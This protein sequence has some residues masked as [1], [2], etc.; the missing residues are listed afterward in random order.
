MSTNVTRGNS[1]SMLH[2][3]P[4]HMQKIAILYDASQAVLATFDLDEVLKQI[5]AIVRD[6]F[7]IQHGAILLLDEAKQELYFRSYFGYEGSDTSLRLPLGQGITGSAAKLKRPLYVLDVTQDPR[8]VETLPGTRSE[9][10]IPLMVRDQVVG[11][12]DCQSHREDVFDNE[13]VDLLT[14]FSTQAS[15][16]LQ[17]AHLH[18]LERRRTAQLEAINAI[19]R[20]TTALLQEDELLTKFST[21]I[22]ESFDV[23]EVCILLL[24]NDRL[25][26]RAQHGRLT[27][28]L[29]EGS[30]LPAISGLSGRALRLGHTVLENNVAAAAD[31]VPGF[32][33]SVSE[34][35]LPLISLGET[36]GVLALESAEQD[37]F[38]HADVPIL[39]SVADICATAIQNARNFA[40]VHQMAYIDGL[41]GA[42]NRRCFEMRIVEELER[43]RRFS[44]GLSLM[45][46]DIDNFKQLNDEFGHLLGDEVLRQVASIFT[47]QLRKID[48]VC[49]YGGDEFAILFE[50]D[51]EGASVVA[52][53]L[54]R[55][56][57]T[58]PFPGVPRPVS[59]SAGIAEFPTHGQTRDQLVSTAD[60][61]LYSAKQAGRNRVVCAGT[62]QGTTAP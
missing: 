23:D 30:Y 40:R 56:I 53:K 20:Q 19:A 29:P 57:A 33:E 43:G 61:A 34:M 42:F 62:T 52:E 41:T 48:V 16:A 49:R 13:T 44:Q 31:Y 58:H 38:Q 39:E 32:V 24:E 21:L 12:L 18:S 7:Q 26:V 28:C 14:L 59:I 54:R 47:Q 6:Y 35:C 1:G 3:R 46:V 5:L 37:A 45:M 8:Y 22:V 60:A 2:F 4:V 10:A 17:N 36:M 50:T 27:P 51:L 55:L 25:V 11:V 9:L 15:I